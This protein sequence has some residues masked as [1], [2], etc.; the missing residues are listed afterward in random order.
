[1][2]PFIAMS[3][4]SAAGG[5]IA[6]AVC[7]RFGRWWGRCGVAAFGMVGAGVFMAAGSQ[8]S[9]RRRGQRGSGG[10]RRFALHRPKR[11]LGALRRLG[12]GFL[13][14]ALRLHQYGR[15]S[16][17]RPHRHYHAR[18]RRSLWLDRFLSDRRRLLRA[19]RRPVAGRQSQPPPYPL[20]AATIVLGL[21][22]RGSD[23]GI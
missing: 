18:Y 11:L 2:L 7:R 4:G 20:G 23:M 14:L 6:D 22:A 15:P 21:G 16:G 10:G 5:W 19:R 8:V 17:Q 3:L 13:R 1:M 9:T 12:K